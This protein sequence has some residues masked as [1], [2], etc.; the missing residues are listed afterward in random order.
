MN[1]E[2]S[3]YILMQTPMSMFRNKSFTVMGFV[4]EVNLEMDFT[5]I[6]ILVITF[7]NKEEVR[8]IFEVFFQG[9]V[10]NFVDKYAKEGD[11]ID[12]TGE[13]VISKTMIAN[14]Q[15]IKLSAKHAYLY[16]KFGNAYKQ[17][18]EIIQ[19]A[20]TENEGLAF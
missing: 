8:E 15:I 12:A 7:K 16:K 3:S 13:M 9:E 5:K 14:N 19:A 18:S 6:K 20:E 1:P 11:L 10:R 17:I 2:K 4:T